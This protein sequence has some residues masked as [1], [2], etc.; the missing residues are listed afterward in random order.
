MRRSS[1]PIRWRLALL[2]ASV[3]SVVLIAFALVVSTTTSARL[4]DDFRQGVERSTDDL[5]TRIKPSIQS[6]DGDQVLDRF[7]FPL[8]SYARGGSAF[9]RVVTAQQ[10]LRFSQKNVSLGPRKVGQSDRRAIRPSGIS[11]W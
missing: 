7:A 1:I 11:T 5:A 3:T 10:V 9:V 4:R 8:T 2:I 6:R